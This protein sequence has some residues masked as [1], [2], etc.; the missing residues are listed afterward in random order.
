MGQDRVKRDKLRCRR[1][2]KRRREGGT[3]E[4]SGGKEEELEEER[5]LGRRKKEKSGRAEGEPR[6]GEGNR[7]RVL[8]RNFQKQ[9]VQRSCGDSKQRPL[10]KTLGR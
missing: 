4:E 5:R 10:G 8:E 2:G 9:H 3:W 6:R 7:G 1:E